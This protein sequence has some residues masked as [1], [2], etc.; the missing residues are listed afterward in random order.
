MKC[1]YFL[2]FIIGQSKEDPLLIPP[3][4]SSDTVNANNTN[5]V[6]VNAATVQR[7]SPEVSSDQILN[8]RLTAWIAGL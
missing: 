8:S 5:A 4:K 3:E 2:L 7:S 1:I 6:E